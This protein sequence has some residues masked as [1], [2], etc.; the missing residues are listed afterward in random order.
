[1]KS[2]NHI[3]TCTPYLDEFAKQFNANTTDISST[4]N[5]EKYLPVN[6]YS[7]DHTIVLGWSGS[8][9]TL[10]IL[11]LILPALTALKDLLDYKLLVMGGTN[12]DIPG[13]QMEKL[14][15]S[16]EKEISTLQ[17]IDIGLYPLPMDEEWVKGKSGL[18]ALQYMALGIP[19]IASNCGCNDRVIHNG[20]S[21]F[22]VSTQEEWIEK[23]I[24]LAKDAALRKSMGKAARSLLKKHTR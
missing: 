8:H 3:I 11:K 17:K 19:T 4:I 2:A 15:W 1:M 16:E 23:I 14:E 12:I 21:G 20:I 10:R 22:L 24:L 9:S 18:K 5:T 13:I 6:T 7:N